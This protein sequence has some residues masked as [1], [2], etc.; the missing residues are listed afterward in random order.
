MFPKILIAG[1]CYHSLNHFLFS[2]F[3]D[4]LKSAA[5]SSQGKYTF[6]CYT[7]SSYLHTSNLKETAANR[8]CQMT[9]DFPN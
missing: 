9:T 2:D 5:Y 7:P 6:L 1:I 4:Y 8:V 3:F